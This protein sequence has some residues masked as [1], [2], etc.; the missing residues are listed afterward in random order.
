MTRIK[1]EAEFAIL[2]ELEKEVMKLS[3]EEF[4]EQFD[5]EKLQQK[6]QEQ[7]HSQFITIQKVEESEPAAEEDT[8]KPTNYNIDSYIE[9][10]WANL[11][12]KFQMTFLDKPMCEIIFEL[13]NA[14]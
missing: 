2:K 7:Q 8:G 12:Q 5:K 3:D 14:R 9:Q 1:D 11:D 4:V 13:P 6:I 10:F